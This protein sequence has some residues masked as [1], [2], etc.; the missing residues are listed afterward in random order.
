MKS[1]LFLLMSNVS[2][3][4]YLYMITPTFY[5]FNLYSSTEVYNPTVYNSTF[6]TNPLSFLHSQKY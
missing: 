4:N 1:S 5:D 6:L 3:S 2:P